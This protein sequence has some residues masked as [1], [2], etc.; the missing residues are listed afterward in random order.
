[1]GHGLRLA[2]VGIAVGAAAADLSTSL[3]ASFVPDL[4]VPTA[5]SI[6]VVAF[7]LFAVAGVAAWV[8]ARRAAGIDPLQAVR[9]V[10]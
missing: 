3:L 5:L 4:D 1:L 10:D 6:A 8:P 2:A 9:A 7:G